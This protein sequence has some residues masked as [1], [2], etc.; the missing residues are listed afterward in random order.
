MAGTEEYAATF[1]L[2]DTDAD[3]LISRDEFKRLLDA[4][5]GG[6]VADEIVASMFG[7]MDADQDG[8]VTLGELSGYLAANPL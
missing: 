7:Q 3:G 5:G 4:L 8:Q 6:S 1:Q 2:I